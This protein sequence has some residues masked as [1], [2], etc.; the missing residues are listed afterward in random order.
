MWGE[1]AGHRW[2]PSTKGQNAENIYIWWRH[3]DPSGTWE[4]H[5]LLCTRFCFKTYYY[6]KLPVKNEV[7]ELEIFAVSHGSLTKSILIRLY[8]SDV[9]SLIQILS[10]RHTGTKKGVD[11][12]ARRLHFCSFGSIAAYRDQPL[13][14]MYSFFRMDIAPQNNWIGSSGQWVINNDRINMGMVFTGRPS[15]RVC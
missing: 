6:S 4:F 15:S 9:T 13:S 11:T 14:I 5:K 7:G 3:H 1:F 2:F 12:A 10:I 8:E